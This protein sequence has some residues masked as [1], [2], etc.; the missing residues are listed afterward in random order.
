LSTRR[1]AFLLLFA[2]LKKYRKKKVMVFFSSCMSVKYHN[3]LLNYIDLPVM[4][5]HGKQK[6]AK[7]TQTFFQFTNAESGILLCTDVAARGLDI[8]QVDWIVQFDPPDDPKEYIHRVGRTARAGNNGHA[9]LVLRPEELGFLRYLKQAKVSLNEF[10]FSWAKIPDI[11][12][13]LE[14]LIEKNYFL[15]MSAKEA[16]KAYI[17][18][19]ASHSMKTVYDVDTLDVQKVGKSFGF[20]VAPFVDLG[21]SAGKGFSGG[22]N[23]KRKSSFQSD[24]KFKKAKIYKNV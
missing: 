20:R 13:Q 5:I 22:N 9:L 11:S 18:A 8:P 1:S 14:N 7:R 16:Y 21:V 19:Y 15:H 4:C 3:E 24:K 2:F 23:N 6:Q 12:D 10:E 17:R